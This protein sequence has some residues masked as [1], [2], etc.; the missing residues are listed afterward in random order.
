MITSSRIDAISLYLK[1]VAQGK[2][3]LDDFENKVSRIISPSSA[4]ILKNV[5]EEKASIKTIDNKIINAAM[6]I[7]EEEFS[8][9]FKSK[10]EYFKGRSDFADEIYGVLFEM[11][12]DDKKE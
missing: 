9:D 11:L 5:I 2:M 7:C 4:K 8:D 1:Q 6:A 10:N 3:R 12:T